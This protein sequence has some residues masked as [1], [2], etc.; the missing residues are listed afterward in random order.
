M[1]KRKSHL[2]RTVPLALLV[3]TF[4][5]SNGPAISQTV[6]SPATTPVTAINPNDAVEEKLFKASSASLTK[7]IEAQA[8]PLELNFKEIKDL[9]SD[10]STVGVKISG[11]SQYVDVEGQK[12]GQLV[13]TGLKKDE[14]AVRLDPNKFTSQF[15]LE[16]AE[17][18][19]EQ[20]LD[21]KGD[22][23][24][25][26]AALRE[27][28]AEE[29]PEEV[30]EKE[31][32]EEKEKPEATE[33]PTSAVQ[34]KGE[35]S[36]ASS[37]KTPERLAAQPDPKEEIRTTTE[38]C[39][40]RIDIPQQAAIEQSKTQT[41]KDG[42]LESEDACSD[43]GTRF[44]LQKS[45]DVC[46]DVVSLD[47]MTAT[48]QFTWYYVNGSAARQDVSEC[49]QDP[50]KIFQIVEKDACV[51][52]I[53]LEAKLATPQTSLVYADN[54]NTETR[55]RDCAA[56]AT[57]PAVPLI[58]STD[59]C[60]IKH[61][62]GAGISKEMGMWT[63]TL[64]GNIFQATPCTDT[65]VTYTHTKVYKTAA[66]GNVCEPIIDLTNRQVAQQ[67]RVEITI[68]GQSQYISECTPDE[69]GLLAVKSTTDTCLNPVNFEHDLAASQ[70]YGLE[71]FYYENPSRVYVS[72]CQK[73]EV[74][75]PHDLET[76]GWQ[77]LDNKKSSY[78]LTTVRITV[79]G[80][81]FE[82]ASST[83]LPG[84][85]LVPYEYVENR[86]DV[87]GG[88]YTGCS[89][90]R[91]TAEVEV[92]KR[93]DTTEYKEV[94][95]AGAPQDPVNAC[96]TIITQPVWEKQSQTGV[97]KTGTRRVASGGMNCGSQGEHQCYKSYTTWARAFTVKGKRV[98]EREDGEQIT[99]ASTK[100]YS[101]V[102]AS[103]ETEGGRT[104]SLSNCPATYV[105]GNVY[106]YNQT[107][108]W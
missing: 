50:E 67:S 9:P 66:G 12:V 47:N 94:I 58:Q 61:E 41:F 27:L 1:L 13:I 35:N 51:I 43:S 85:S 3:A 75:Y 44:T 81:P 10:V 55:V 7:L 102:C 28:N 69:S 2:L 64:E 72:E 49:L 57:K 79:N 100:T 92:Y 68:D 34:N 26:I 5:V 74:V 18:P 17:L 93:P 71:R 24:E 48:A 36:Q 63:Y 60:T 80:S 70:S 30:A 83:V 98:L 56:S 23:Q 15:D 95:G 11:Y 97:Y 20:A 103:G 54:N 78:P 25:L 53:D 104:P 16:A 108:G 8:T 19:T 77:N 31:E 99:Q 89:V 22:R 91:T 6:Q 52:D 76:T 21:I 38:G 62:F 88:E 33:K 65:G 42:L 90:V 87:V 39:N 37:Y 107:E 86:E 32:K 4:T 106:N 84:E 29:A 45:Y 73:S 59:T 96:G 105:G 40:V 14:K 82:V 101:N 46:K